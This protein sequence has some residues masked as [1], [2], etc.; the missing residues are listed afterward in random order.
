M[1]EDEYGQIADAYRELLLPLVD[2]ELAKEIFDR[3]WLPPTDTD[4]FE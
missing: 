4:I 3:E 1:C 2:E